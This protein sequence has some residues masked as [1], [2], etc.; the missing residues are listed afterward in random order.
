MPVK[1]H[2]A[3][4]PDGK[5]RPY[6]PLTKR[7][8]QPRSLVSSIQDADGAQ[9]A[10]DRSRGSGGSV[11]AMR[12]ARTPCVRSLR[13]HHRPE[14]EPVAEGAH[15]GAE[16]RRGKVARASQRCSRSTSPAVLGT[17]GSRAT[18]PS[19]SRYSALTAPAEGTRRTG[20]PPTA[21]SVPQ[22]AEA[23]AIRRC[24]SRPRASR[25]VS[26]ATPLGFSRPHHP[27]HSR[28]AR[29]LRR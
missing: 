17:R 9:P 10:G 22:G 5:T 15:E 20:G 18:I 3:T 16:Q 29:S 25:P 13:D 19:P 11:R 2:R 28:S 21:G 4:L 7:A 27:P 6:A 1:Y 14:V 24:A 12:A 8:L 23:P 26:W